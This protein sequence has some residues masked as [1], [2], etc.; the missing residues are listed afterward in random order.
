[1]LNVILV[2]VLVSIGGATF[3]ALRSSSSS[4]ATTQTTATAKRGTVLESVT[5]T[6]NVEAPT[7]LS[8]SFQQSGEVT[9]IYVKAGQHVVEGQALA[10]VDD[11][12]QSHAL[13]SAQASL[14]SAQAALA[15]LKRGETDG[16]AC[17]GRDVDRVRRR[18]RSHR[19]SR[20]SRSASRR[21][22]ERDEVPAGDRPGAVL[23]HE[24]QRGRFDRA[25]RI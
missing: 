1:M 3:A 10:Q 19:R 24:R 14:A 9:A 8:L 25:D 22:R 21:R 16:R 13:A 2:V 12:Q 11:T 18:S 7:S 15:A 4:S 23:V 5:S 17:V 20:A 6:G